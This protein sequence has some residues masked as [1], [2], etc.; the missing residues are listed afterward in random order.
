MMH[1]P[2]HKQTTAGQIR[3]PIPQPSNQE[4]PMD[5]KDIKKFIHDEGEK[6]VQRMTERTETLAKIYGIPNL[7]HI[8]PIIVTLDGL[9]H[10][11]T[12]VVAQATKDIDSSDRKA[13]FDQLQ[14]IFGMSISSICENL[15][16]LAGVE[17]DE[18]KRTKLLEDLIDVAKER[19][20]LEN[21][22]QEM[23]KQAGL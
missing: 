11:V 15:M 4:K 22:V 2:A 10:I 7:E 3:Q 17:A 14:H 13:A 20:A 9:M 1:R 12:S 23:I 21:R 8:T 18:S 6:S 16:N 19:Q 5:I